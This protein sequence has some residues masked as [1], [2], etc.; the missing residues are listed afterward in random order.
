MKGSLIVLAMILPGLA[1]DPDPKAELARFQGV[2]AVKKCQVGEHVVAGYDFAIIDGDKLT[3]TRQGKR[4][5]QP[6]IFTIDPTKKP[7]E[8]DFPPAG[9]A[10]Q[11]LGIYKLEGDR[12]TYCYNKKRPVNFD[13]EA[14]KQAPFNV[15][16]IFERMDAARPE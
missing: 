10:A 4:A 3:L 14:Q 13:P 11:S 2:W 5:P 12:L 15:L 16:F 6:I 1:D 7:C 9:T 8:I